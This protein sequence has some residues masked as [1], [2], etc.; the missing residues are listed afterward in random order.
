[1]VAATARTRHRPRLM[2]VSSNP[3]HAKGPKDPSGKWQGTDPIFFHRSQLKIG[4]RI[5][6][7]G[8]LTHGQLWEVIEIYTWKPDGSGNL[9]RTP[10]REVTRLTDDIILQTIRQPRQIRQTTFSTM[11]YS[12]IWRLL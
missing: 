10:A 9:I 12:A 8:R 7:F 2:L 1:M 4:T 3:P 6:N 5:L 11:S